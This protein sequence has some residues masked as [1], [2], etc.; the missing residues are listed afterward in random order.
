MP[1]WFYIDLHQIEL[2]WAII[3]SKIL[4][5]EKK[6]EKIECSIWLIIELMP[7]I[8]CE[9]PNHPGLITKNLV[10]I[11]IEVLAYI[12][13]NNIIQHTPYSHLETMF[14][15]EVKFTW[16][17]IAQVY[18]LKSGSITGEYSGVGHPPL[19]R[20]AETLP[21]L[22]EILTWLKETLTK[23]KVPL[24]R[25]IPSPSPVMLVIYFYPC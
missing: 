21:R 14:G 1:L 7:S 2:K 11:R 19:S 18:L 13:T 15:A 20:A 9:T 16:K 23:V 24:T 3:E 17:T 4:Y 12:Q 22:E 5:Q 6:F 8:Q 25:N 10:Y